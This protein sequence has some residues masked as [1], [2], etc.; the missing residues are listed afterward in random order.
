M[1]AV[2]MIGEN[3]AIAVPKQ[4]CTMCKRP[5]LPIQPVRYNTPMCFACFMFWD[6]Q[7]Q[8]SLKLAIGSFPKYSPVS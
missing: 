8:R 4:N 7:F 5:C 2:L 1:V 3:V 6:E